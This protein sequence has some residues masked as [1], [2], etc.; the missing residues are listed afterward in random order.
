L[1]GRDQC[2]GSGISVREKIKFQ[3][4]NRLRERATTENTEGTE[5]EKQHAVRDGLI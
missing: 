5:E 1:R 2:E 4:V 3:G